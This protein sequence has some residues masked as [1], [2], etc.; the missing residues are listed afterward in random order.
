MDSKKV[1]ESSKNFCCNFCNYNT[2]N[3]FQYIVIYLHIN[4]K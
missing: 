4:M 1:Q 3:K 2:Y